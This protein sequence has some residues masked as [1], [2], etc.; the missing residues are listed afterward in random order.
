M[1]GIRKL[2]VKNKIH[3]FNFIK[4]YL[5]KQFVNSYPFFVAFHMYF[6]KLLNY[7]KQNTV[8]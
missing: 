2:I 8:E 7:T 3:C 4:L 6:D 5:K 1:F